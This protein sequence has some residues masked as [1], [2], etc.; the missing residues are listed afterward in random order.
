[1]AMHKMICKY[2]EGGDLE[3]RE[4]RKTHAITCFCAAIS[5][6]KQCVWADSETGLV[7]T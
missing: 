3:Q 5:V 7:G 1:M 6:T 2:C 4:K